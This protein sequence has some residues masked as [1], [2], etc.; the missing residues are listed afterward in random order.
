MIHNPISYKNN[1]TGEIIKVIDVFEDVAVLEN[2]TKV[3]ISGYTQINQSF[4][5]KVDPESF[6]N[7]Q[8][9]Y[10]NIASQIANISPN[11]IQDDGNNGQLVNIKMDESVMSQFTPST[12]ESALIMVDEEDEI[13]ELSRKYN[14]INNDEVIQ[15]NNAFDKILNPDKNKQDNP[16]N[17]NNNNNNRTSQ[18]EDPMIVM[19]KNVK[20]N[21]EF[22]IT[23]DIKNKIPRPDFIEMMEDSYEV[24]IIDYL[25]TEF[26][27]NIISNPSMIED[28][29]R[30]KIKEIVYKTK[31][32]AVI[33]R[34]T[35]SGSAG[36][37]GKTPKISKKSSS[38]NK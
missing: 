1:K 30:E 10:S 11:N 8:N 38:K 35:S 16:N 7:N 32:N 29:I 23:L 4:T 19:F 9:T 25:A 15:Q 13:S 36:T 24:S 28:M 3:N 17:N 37:S 22:A 33:C 26:T 21:T 2:M 27:N 31:S 20:K 18:V 5:D 34:G 6:F 14:I 12:T